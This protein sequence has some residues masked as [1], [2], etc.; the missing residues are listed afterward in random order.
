M[1]G[2]VQYVIEGWDWNEILV[3]SSIVLAAWIAARVFFYLVGRIGGLWA[4][5]TASSLDDYIL[6]AIRRPVSFLIFLIGIYLALHRYSFVLLPFLDGLIFVVSVFLVVFTLIRVAVAFLRWYS[7]KVAREKEG[8]ALAHELLPIVDKVAK[9]IFTAIGLIVILDHFRIEIKSILVTLGVGT[10][11]IGLALQETL[12]NMFG[13]FTIMLD[14]PFRLGDRIQLSSGEMGD[15]QEI[16][17]RSTRVL[18][19]EGNVL[20]I[21]NAILVKSMMTNYSFPDRRSRIIIDVGVAYGTDTRF[22]KKLMLEAA[23][24]HP[25]VMQFPEPVA[26]FKSFGESALN[27]SLICFIADF[28]NRLMVTDVL[29]T[30][31]NA[32]FAAAGVEIPYPIRSVRIRDHT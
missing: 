9:L 1:P 22:A 30:A 21:P 28:R 27:L 10:L 32:K 12:A 17:I 13:G 14:R 2:W 20:V 4:R 31:I 24:E 3:T 6:D 19:M 8:E 16:G 26:V 5:R 18:T 15:V 23:T 25:G 7:E 29:N 11:A